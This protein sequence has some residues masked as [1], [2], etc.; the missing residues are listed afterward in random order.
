[1]GGRFHSRHFGGLMGYKIGA[2]GGI[3]AGFMVNWGFFMFAYWGTSSLRPMQTV[4][5]EPWNGLFRLQPL[6]NSSLHHAE[7][8]QCER[9]C[10]FRGCYPE[11]LRHAP[12]PGCNVE[13]TARWERAHAE[14]ESVTPTSSASANSLSAACSTAVTAATSTSVALRETI[15]STLELGAD[16]ISG[17]CRDASADA[18]PGRPVIPSSLTAGCFRASSAAS[19]HASYAKL[20][21][22]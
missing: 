21:A 3:L 7:S 2:I 18:R 16:A 5:G 6:R 15:L 17:V 1:M 10:P 11:K 14:R 19:S 22:P 13:R 20:A 4:A 12:A 8:T 9:L